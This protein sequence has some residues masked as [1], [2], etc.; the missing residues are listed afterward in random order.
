MHY[1]DKNKYN[2]MKF[3]IVAFLF[4][5]LIVSTFAACDQGYWTSVDSD[6][7]DICTH[8]TD[9]ELGVRKCDD[10]TGAVIE[11]LDDTLEG[12][13]DDYQ[14]YCSTTVSGVP[15]IKF[16]NDGKCMNDCKEGCQTCSIDF[17]YCTD[18]EPGYVWNAD[19]TCLPSVIGLLATTLVLLIVGLVFIVISFMKVN[20][21][22]K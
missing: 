15:Y 12:Y 14:G 6:G 19:Y 2:T 5:M 4:A 3:T 9:Y 1:H 10:A 11:G 16:W 21:A 8:C 20:A 17:D 18:C 22:A 13:D 7:E